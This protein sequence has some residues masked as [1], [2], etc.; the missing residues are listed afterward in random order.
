MLLK[1]VYK[2]KPYTVWLFLIFLLAAFN[3]IGLFDFLNHRPASFHQWAQCDRASVA[4]NFYQQSMNIFLPRTHFIGWGTGIT[5]M[6]FPLMNWLAALSY[7]LFGFHEIQYRL[8]MLFTFTGALMFAY[9]LSMHFSGNSFFISS[10]TVFLFCL[11]PVLCFYAPNFIPD[12][13]SVSFTIVAWFLYLANRSKSTATYYLFVTVL[14][15]SSMIKI[16]GLISV[17]SIALLS[18]ASAFIWKKETISEFIKTITACAIAIIFTFIWYRYARYL[19]EENSAGVF[20]LQ[21]HPIDSLDSLKD[22]FSVIV[23]GVG[24]QYY[25]YGYQWFLLFINL[26]IIIRLKFTDRKLLLITLLLY[27]GGL[28]FFLLMGSQ[29]REHD[30]YII[31]LLPAVLFNLITFFNSIQTLLMKKFWIR[32][33]IIIVFGLFANYLMVYCKKNYHNRY[34]KEQYYY[35]LKADRYFDMEPKLETAGI[36]AN[37]LIIYYGDAAPNTALY[38]MNRRGVSIAEG[39]LQ[40]VSDFAHQ[41]KFRYLLLDK[42]SYEGEKLLIPFLTDKVATINE[43]SIFKLHD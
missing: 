15:L 26:V 33:T 39:Q 3:N 2:M 12:T 24:I 37:D 21:M 27:A 32:I 42:Q 38:L 14:A 28:C 40:A 25:A 6:E 36:K 30:Y 4:L 8:I 9:R 18:F 41:K 7:H 23:S 34:D 5:G 16:T 43:I 20:T 10:V 31:T 35:N 29:F 22:L 11:S 17:V 13:A 19:N 1:I